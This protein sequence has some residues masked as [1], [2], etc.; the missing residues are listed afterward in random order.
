MGRST[1]RHLRPRA[2][3]KACD[4]AGAELIY[5]GGV[6]TLKDL[7]GLAKMGAASLTGVIVGRALYDERLTVAE[8]IAALG[9]G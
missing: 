7:E 8:A 6:G 1:A 2:D 5:S 9:R 3:L 4:A